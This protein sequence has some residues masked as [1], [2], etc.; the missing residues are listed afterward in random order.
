MD[1]L[2]AELKTGGSGYHGDPFHYSSATFD[3]KTLLRMLNS[4][5]AW[6][7]ASDAGQWH[8]GGETEKMSA[9]FEHGY[10]ILKYTVL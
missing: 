7:T 2:L 9:I 3:W 4:L 8:S 1:L 6:F 10:W 5:N